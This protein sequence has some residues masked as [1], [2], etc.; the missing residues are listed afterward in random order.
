MDDLPVPFEILK[1]HSLKMAANRDVYLEYQKFD[2]VFPKRLG[3]KLLCGVK[4]K[5]DEGL[6]GKNCLIDL[7]SEFREY[8]IECPIT[9]VGLRACWHV[10]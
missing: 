1:F 6:S 10:D 3:V 7:P 5:Y 8:E 2:Q 4:E 9:P